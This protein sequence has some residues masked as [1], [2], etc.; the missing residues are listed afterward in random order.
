M[1]RRRA[2]ARGAWSWG[3]GLFA[4]LV[5]ATLAVW[6]DGR[7]PTEG[8]REVRGQ[9]V[10][11][12]AEL[13]S[14]SDNT[15][16]ATT[17]RP[18]SMPLPGT[19]APQ[20][21]V[22]AGPAALEARVRRLDTGELLVGRAVR[23]VP[24]PGGPLG[25]RDGLTNESGLVR[26][27]WD[28]A[29]LVQDVVLLPDADTGLANLGR[30]V[31]LRPGRVESVDLFV[32]PGTRL[33]GLVLDLE[34]TPV[35]G[36]TVQARSHVARPWGADDITLTEN[37]Q[38]TTA[39]TWGRFVL[40]GVGPEFEL[41][42]TAPGWALRFGIRGRTAG[43]RQIAGLEVLLARTRLLHGRVEEWDGRP[44]AGIE[45]T[46]SP[47]D[48]APPAQQKGLGSALPASSRSLGVTDARGRFTTSSLT[49][50][51]WTLEFEE[52]RVRRF[53]QR[54]TLTEAGLFA[55][56]DDGRQ[57]APHR[58]DEEVPF[59]LPRM[60]RVSGRVVDERGEAVAYAEVCAMPG[61]PFPA[62]AQGRFVMESPPELAPSWVLA[63]AP[64]TDV[65]AVHVPADP[66]SELL[67]VL[68]RV[69]TGH[70]LNGRVVD[71]FD[72]G[73]PGVHVRLVGTRTL[74]PERRPDVHGGPWTWERVFRAHE[75]VTDEGGRFRF[76]GLR[77][78]PYRLIAR[79]AAD[80]RLSREI[81]VL[82]GSG[83]VVLVLDPGLDSH[84]SVRG[85]VY[86]GETGQ[87]I[88]A[89]RVVPFDEMGGTYAR[90]EDSIV[91]AQGR[92]DIRNLNPGPMR[93]EIKAPGFATWSTVAEFPAG[94]T[95]LAPRLV[96]STSLHVE[97]LLTDGTPAADASVYLSDSSGTPIMMHSNGS[98]TRHLTGA[99]GRVRL[100][101]L[102]AER[103]ELLVEWAPEWR[104]KFARRAEQVERRWVDLRV[105]ADRDQQVRLQT[106]EDPEPT[107]LWVH[108]VTAPGAPSL[109]VPVRIRVRS[110]DGLEEADWTLAP[111]AEGFKFTDQVPRS[112]STARVPV[113]VFDQSVELTF[114]AAGYTTA[115]LLISPGDTRSERHVVLNEAP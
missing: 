12:P 28:R 85:V 22:A 60:E 2:D 6:L 27:E 75:T 72:A 13:P 106:P 54:V 18:L 10:R 44:V 53:T 112:F 93:L 94:E 50:G 51:G 111:V 34:G 84:A 23:A 32:L 74:E 91:D 45:I 98:A 48:L 96:P 99:D 113:Q 25:P 86:D 9:G 38:S 70:E 101:D 30:S 97:V 63:R 7:A 78:E 89:F 107:S 92:F 81:E 103:L 56:R 110:K 19:T 49:D 90:L 95:V 47:L 71:G 105:P 83:D 115:R 21:P 100:T 41:H 77:A 14:A 33:S 42:A 36:A 11:V 66:E 29:L 5:I 26:F 88:T 4:L 24:R 67:D 65:G 73:L 8:K 31:R 20:A 58:A 114:D 57:G 55:P 59:R 87:P 3:L 35:P 1:T 40:D 37:M 52:N 39:D 62:D 82:P 108:V 69:S 17:P 46:A 16:G 76:D 68:I 64:G 80:P 15:H 43:V 102:P 79:D 104:Q 109:S 61:R